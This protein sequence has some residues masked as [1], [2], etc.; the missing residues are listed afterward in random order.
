MA[1]SATSLELRTP[2]GAFREIDTWLREQGFFARGSEELVADLYLGYGLSQ[3]IR[4]TRRR[5]PPEPCP[6]L[7]LAGSAPPRRTPPST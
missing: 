4:R 1:G 7:P 5:T 2:G 3:T 6:S